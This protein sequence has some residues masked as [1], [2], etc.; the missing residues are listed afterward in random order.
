MAPHDPLFKSL[1][2]TFFASF[3]RLVAPDVAARLDLS[4]PIF[5]DKE[6]TAFDPPARSRLV[7][8]LARV[9]LKE[10][11][12][13]TLLIHTEVE[14][15]VRGG[16][17]ERI[18]SYQRWIQTRHEG[19]IL[20][21]VLFLHGGRAGVCEQAISGELAGPGLP[22]FRYLSFGLDRCRAAEYLEKPEP[23]A[24]ALA[25]LMDRRPWSRAELKI[26]CLARIAEATLA[27][28]ERRELVNCVETY[29]QLTSSEAGEVSF[30]G[31]LRTRRAQDMPQSLLF[32]TSWADKMILE[33]ERRG[34]REVLLGLVEE[35]FGSVPAET[36]RR[37]ESIQSVDRLKRLCHKVLTAKTVKGLRLG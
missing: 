15:R 35:R 16:I 36:R 27:E 14:N 12:G 34:T 10:A 23:L 21:I 19:Q 4:T 37:I 33:G 13:R 7:D 20:S 2:R 1:L 28:E 24:W 17:G 5:L 18:R 9:P 22:V 25:A 3:L 31:N 6:L 30:P 26:H 8:L 32:R 11:S 29:L